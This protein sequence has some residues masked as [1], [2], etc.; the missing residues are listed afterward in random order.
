MKRLKLIFNSFFSLNLDLWII[1]D[2]LTCPITLCE[3]QRGM[4]SV[5][6]LL[7]EYN[8]FSKTYFKLWVVLFKKNSHERWS[9]LYQKASL[10]YFIFFPFK[11]IIR[12]EKILI[13]ANDFCNS[14]LFNCTSLFVFNKVNLSKYFYST[15]SLQENWR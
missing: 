6:V 12:K 1:R 3:S 9:I 11:L 8:Y 7:C 4:W 15:F 14:F 2:S 10:K 13:K 5:H